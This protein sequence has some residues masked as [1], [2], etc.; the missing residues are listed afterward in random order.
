MESLPLTR[1]RNLHDTVAEFCALSGSPGLA[2]GVLHQAWVLH[3]DNFGYADVQAR[4]PATSDTRYCT[5]SLTKALT[6][7]AVGTLVDDGKLSCE[8]SVHELLGDGF[9]FSDPILTKKMPFWDLLSHRMGLQRSNQLWYGNENLLLLDKSK[10]LPH[11][12]S[13]KPFQRYNSTVHYSNWGYALAGHIV[14]KIS[15]ESWSAYVGKN[16]LGPLHM[17]S[18]DSKN[19]VDAKPYTVLD[20]HSFQLL[21]CV[22]VQ[23]GTIMESSQGIRSTASDMLKW[24]QA[25]I[26]AYNVEQNTSPGYSTSSPLKQLSKK[27]SVLHHLQNLSIR[28]LRKV[29]AGFVHNFLRPWALLAATQVS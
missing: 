18:T 29:P 17:Y 19:N 20:N 14:E 15:G 1:L 2:Y 24:S 13:L 3:T 5:G 28:V 7:A 26:T 22:K 8:T 25:T 9:H 12:Q 27:M 11:V 10:A 4:L 23:E 16:L 6:F 21:P